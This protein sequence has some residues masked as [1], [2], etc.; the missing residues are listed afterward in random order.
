MGRVGSVPCSESVEG[1]NI[2]VMDDRQHWL[3][4]KAV[5]GGG[6]LEFETIAVGT[7]RVSEGV[8]RGR[9]EILRRTVQDGV[10]LGRVR[11]RPVLLPWITL[12]AIWTAA[13]S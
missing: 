4:G 7:R 10:D 5:H 1:R 12:I 2:K 9:C 3:A 13:M 11:V 6:S 8:T